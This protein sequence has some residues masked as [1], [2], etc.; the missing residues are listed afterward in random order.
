[1]KFSGIATLSALLGLSAAT[2]TQK[3]K[4]E[5]DVVCTD[6]PASTYTKTVTVTAP[7]TYGYPGPA[8]TGYPWVKTVDGYVTSYDYNGSK[9]TVYVYP[10][11]SASH[12]ATVA[13]YDK[14]VIVNVFII[15]IDVTVVNGQ[16]TTKTVTKTDKPTYTPLPPPPKETYTASTSTSKSYSYSTS[17][18]SAHNAKQTHY[19]QVGAQGQLVYGP[20]QL[21]AK[22]GDI[23]RFDFLKLNHTVTQS[24][25]SKPCTPNG[26]FDTGF[27]Q[28][29]PQNISGKFIVDFYVNTTSP[30]WF[31]CKQSG[32]CNKGMVLGINPQDK[33]PQFLANAEAQGKPASKGRRAS[34]WSA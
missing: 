1:M 19:V 25:F 26:G 15:N 8:A 24:S 18:S 6:Y 29:N 27:N 33:F 31:Y 13:V 5:V 4:V 21:N 34:G 9:T 14:T 16:T 10:T 28:F 20:N 12:D 7:P 22:V 2:Y 17:T 32:H 23:V 3:T 30:L 11:G